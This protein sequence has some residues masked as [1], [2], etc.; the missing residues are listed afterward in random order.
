MGQQMRRITPKTDESGAIPG[1]SEAALHRL[2]TSTEK[3][4]PRDLLPPGAMVQCDPMDQLD[5]LRLQL[6]S[7]LQGVRSARPVNGTIPQVEALLQQA[8]GLLSVGPRDFGAVL[9]AAR[10][11]AGLSQRRIAELAGVSERTMKYL[12]ASKVEPRPDTLA[13]LYA[14]PGLRL[15]EHLA[16]PEGTPPPTWRPNSWFAPRYEPARLMRDLV[17]LVNGPGGVL[18]QTALYLDGRSAMDYLELCQSAPLYQAFRRA[19]PNDRVAAL[20]ARQLAG[21]KAV[22]VNALGSGDGTAETGFVRELAA[23]LPARLRLQLLD[24]SHT[25]LCVAHRTAAEALA[26]SGVEVLSLHA[27][28]HDLPRYQILH[29]EPGGD[30]RVYLMLGATIANLEN[31]VRFF[32]DLANVAAPGDL[33]LVDCQTVRAPANQPDDI[34]RAEPT[35]THGPAPTHLEWLTGPI[36]RHCRDAKEVHLT[37]D[38]TTLCPVPGSYELDCTAT[39][40]L[41]GGA[42]K[43]FLVWRGKRYSPEGLSACLSSLGWREIEVLRFDEYAAMLVMRRG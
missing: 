3:T 28:F 29:G 4:P 39:V 37:M 41:A 40:K 30:P 23:A 12:E 42:T 8:L 1:N 22:V 20:C 15:G 6:G 7:L 27:N 33:L 26:A 21:A 11:A 5:G 19:T 35:L 36:R 34:R 16:T 2:C 38:L 32:G 43:R 14:I 25:L 24:I 9:R 13:R 31:E 10:N 17:D 18:E